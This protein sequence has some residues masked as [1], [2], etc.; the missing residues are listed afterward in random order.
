MLD[1]MIQDK[2]KCLFCGQLYVVDK[3]DICKKCVFS[4][5]SSFSP[6]YVKPTSYRRNA[7]S[8]PD[9]ILDTINKENLKI[10]ESPTLNIIENP[11]LN[12]KTSLKSVTSNPNLSRKSSLK[13]INNDFD[14]VE[15]DNAL[16]DLTQER[17]KTLPN[18]D[19]L[20]RSIS[21]LL[22][23]HLK[24]KIFD[25]IPTLPNP[26]A[27]NKTSSTSSNIRDLIQDFDDSLEQIVLEKR[28]ALEK[29]ILKHTKSEPK[30]KINL[31]NTIHLPA[32]RNTI[33]NT[34]TL[35]NFLI[36]DNQSQNQK[37]DF[38]K[39]Q[40][41]KD[42]Q[43]KILEAKQKLRQTKK[44]L[45]EFSISDMSASYEAARIEYSLAERE[46]EEAC[47]NWCKTMR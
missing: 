33:G 4:Q 24:P 37:T 27:F 11:E 26:E 29:S 8:N 38:E 5:H 19:E 22:K 7:L 21:P 42:L 14:L 3:H 12:K 35:K 25:R 46:V 39:K 40:K 47:R 10:I 9:F 1:M 43:N 16:A 18:P 20:R 2:K 28:K 34:N 23:I 36:Q 44:T 15:V 32:R 31:N 41:L 6:H 45:E 13:S 17:R 30:I